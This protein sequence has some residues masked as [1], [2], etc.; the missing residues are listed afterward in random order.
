M[1]TLLTLTLF[2]IFCSF[3]QCIISQTEDL[4]SECNFLNDAWDGPIATDTCMKSVVYGGGNIDSYIFQCDAQTNS[5]AAKSYWCNGENCVGTIDN[6]AN[7]GLLDGQVFSGKNRSNFFHYDYWNC[8]G[9]D[10]C[11]K[12]TIKYQCC[13]GSC[14]GGETADRHQVTYVQNMCWRQY[15][16]PNFGGLMLHCQDNELII[17]QYKY[18]NCTDLLTSAPYN[19]TVHF[20]WETGYCSDM[21]YTCSGAHQNYILFNVFVVLMFFCI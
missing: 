3:I 9:R 8:R 19:K 12:V 5:I 14:Y 15:S 17:D 2:S 18:N 6:C 16:N 21:T 7:K 13:V 10:D 20:L 11:D 1:A 4:E